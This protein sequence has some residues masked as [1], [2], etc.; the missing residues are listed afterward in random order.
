MIKNYKAF[1]LLEI[2]IVTVIAALMIWAF[3]Y[4]MPNSNNEEKLIKFWIEAATD[5]FNNI[6]T[7][8]LNLI[9]NKTENFSGHKTTIQ[10]INIFFKEDWLIEINE[11]Y[12]P[13][14]YSTSKEYIYN[15]NEYIILG[16]TK[17]ISIPITKDS[18]TIINISNKN[19]PKI[20]KQ[21]SQIHFNKAAQT[22]TQKFC[23]VRDTEKD[24]H[25][26]KIWEK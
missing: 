24:E 17:Q 6:K 10:M 4:F 18:V 3:G 2:L 11:L 23:L 22:I 13:K 12:Y 8:H 20:Y 14:T 21:I 25:N 15:N 1:T 5:I 9:R 19:N 26:C 7:S 16:S